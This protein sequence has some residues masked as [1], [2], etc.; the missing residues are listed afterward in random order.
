[1][2]IKTILVVDDSHT[3]RQHLTEFFDRFAAIHVSEMMA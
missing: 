1:M 2:A 3:D